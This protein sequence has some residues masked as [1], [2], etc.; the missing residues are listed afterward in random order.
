MAGRTFPVLSVVAEECIDTGTLSRL[1]LAVAP[2]LGV[3]VQR[4]VRGSASVASLSAEEAIAT[5]KVGLAFGVPVTGLA[6]AELV[7]A[8]V[9]AKGDRLAQ[10]AVALAVVLASRSVAEASACQHGSWRS[11][12]TSEK[13]LLVSRVLRLREGGS[14]AC[15]QCEC[16]K[17][18]R[19]LH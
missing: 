6:V 8:S 3:H 9:E 10:P 14:E 1:A 17:T 15:G 7:T 13:D 19:Y 5:A 11:R 18:C 2:A 12:E 4:V 16:Q